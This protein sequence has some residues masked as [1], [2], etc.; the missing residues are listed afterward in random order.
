MASLIVFTGA[1]KGK[2]KLYVDEPFER[3]TRWLNAEKPWIAVT[4]S[5][6]TV[7][8]NTTNIAYVKDMGDGGGPPVATG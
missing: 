1:D 2:L 7:V 4:S 5:E 3:I 8:V 6:A